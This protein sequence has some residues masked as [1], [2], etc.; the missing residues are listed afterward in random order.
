MILLNKH[1]FPFHLGLIAHLK[2][3]A[4][5]LMKKIP[6]INNKIMLEINKT[7]DNVYADV[8]SSNKGTLFLQ[9]LPAFG[10]TDGQ[11]LDMLDGYKKL[12]P[13]DWKDGL[14]SGCVYGADDDV[15]D[16]VT[17]VYHKFA[18]ANQMHADV[19]PDIRK[20]EAEVVRMTTE[21][22]NGGEEACGTMS[23][24]GTESIM[25]AC[26]A[27]RELAKTKGIKRPEMICPQTCHAAF[28]KASDCFKI[29]I[30]L[31]DVDPVTMK[32]D[33]KKM[34]SYINSNTCMIAG[35]APNFPNG[36]MDPIEE[37]S[38]LGLKYGIP[39]HVDACLGGY[40]IPFMEQSGY[41]TPTIFDFRL[42]GVTS[43]SCD[44]HKVRFLLSILTFEFISNL[45]VNSNSSTATVRK[46]LR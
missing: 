15:T 45:M 41:K 6:F 9:E 24:G 37:L 1:F 4:F 31:V 40:L 22:Y 18:W 30:H 16:L 10:K 11:I 8:L 2:R 17:K 42:P 20:M 36:A 25:L 29:K 27:Y 39:V 38:Q 46:A 44:T 19:F 7:K 21:L 26:R 5:E 33:V 12:G 23:S 14:L 43:I 34:E 28:L 32:A 13:V 3:E 35:S